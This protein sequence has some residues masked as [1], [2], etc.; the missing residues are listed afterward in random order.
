LQSFGGVD[1]TLNVT[2]FQ[3]M[4]SQGSTA[5]G[6]GKVSYLIDAA[7]G[8]TVSDKVSCAGGRQGALSKDGSI[9]YCFY[10][11]PWN[12]TSTEE[13][14][15]GLKAVDLQRNKTLWTANRSFPV[16]VDHRSV[17][18]L[19]LDD[20]T[21]IVW[22]SQGTFLKPQCLYGYNVTSGIEV[23]R[24]DCASNDYV[25]FIQP[26]L[27]HNGQIVYTLTQPY[28]EP[29]SLKAIRW[30]DETVLWKVGGSEGVQL[31]VDGNRMAVGPTGDVF[32]LLSM[33]IVGGAKTF[34]RC[35]DG[36]NGTLKWTFPLPVL[37]RKASLAI[38]VS[39]NMALITLTEVGFFVVHLVNG[40]GSG[41]SLLPSGQY[42]KRG[43]LMSNGVFASGNGGPYL[44]QY[45]VVTKLDHLFRSK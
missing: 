7:S 2:T 4:V 39:R 29:F 41:S 37:A 11:N 8:T 24:L 23:A 32:L 45:L 35:F 3:A 1:W 6:V 22:F 42:V 9:L 18:E 14:T 26:A 38:D 25:N 21:G 15:G 28:K 17:S 33:Q 36:V 16:A 31:P 20:T 27:S 10:F 5:V 44:D 19:T 34:L 13:A 12:R 30:S 43:I 40:V